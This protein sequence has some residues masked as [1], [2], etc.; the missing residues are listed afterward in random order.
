MFQC[1]RAIYGIQVSALS[2]KGAILKIVLSLLVLSVLSGCGGGGGSNPSGTGAL[3][4]E[5]LING[6]WNFSYHIGTTAYHTYFELRPI[7]MGLPT[8]TTANFSFATTT[9]DVNGIGVPWLVTYTLS[10][11]TWTVQ[12]SYE[13]YVFRTDGAKVSDDACLYQTRLDGTKSPCIPLTGVKTTGL[14][15]IGSSSN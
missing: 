8:P 15:T 10:N 6:S 4:A 5:K 9:T 1:K 7:N 2:L 11:D 3:P 14:P 13:E 12:N